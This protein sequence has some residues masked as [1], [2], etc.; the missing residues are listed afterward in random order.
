MVTE[1]EPQPPSYFFGC[2]LLMIL[3][4]FVSPRIIH[5]PY[6]L[7]GNIP[8][9]IGLGINYYADILFKNRTSIKPA[10][11]PDAFINTGPFKYSR[12]PMYL[13]GIFIIAGIAVLLGTLLPW[14]GV[15]LFWAVLQ[16]KFIPHEEEVME[17]TFGQQ[18]R[19]YKK[20]VRQW[21]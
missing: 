20:R 6:I 21:I 16:F 9:L 19:N 2:V 1:K 13:G 12:N 3:L 4:H 8:L 11:T 18:Y 17:R 10:D 7:I 14:I 5:F 15:F